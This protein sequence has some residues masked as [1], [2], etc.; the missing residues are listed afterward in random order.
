MTKIKWIAMALIMALMLA[1]LTGCGEQKT[2]KEDL[3]EQLLVGFSQLGSESTWRLGNTKSM[4][5]AAEKYNINLMYINANQSQENQKKALRSFI[6]YRV[7]VIAF[8]PIVEDGWDDVL[9]EAKDANIPVI[10][11]DRGI[12]TE[13]S[14]LYASHVGS[15]FYNEGRRAGQYLLKKA[16]KMGSNRL[17]IV[18]ITGTEGSTPMLERQRG[19]KDALGDDERFTIMET[20]CGDFIISKGKEV[21]RDLLEKYGKEIDVVFSQ[22]DGM[23]SGALEAIEEAGFVPGKDIIVISVDGDQGAIDLLREGKINCVVECSPMLGDIVMDV[24]LK[25]VNGE[26]V[27]REYYSTETSFTEFDDVSSIA[28]RGY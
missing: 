25:L 21:M 8:A 10:L 15:D 2:D 6:G 24:V 5:E 3:K 28:P 14:T 9:K 12:Q 20:V 19:F 26:N 17:N 4:F 16:D 18:E 7:D 23:T 13:D 1:L 11:V 27:E 22:N